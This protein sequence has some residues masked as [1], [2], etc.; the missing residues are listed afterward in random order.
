MKLEM[1][2]YFPDT[3][4][5]TQF[6]GAISRWVVL[7]NSQFDAW[8]FLSFL[9]ATS[10]GPQVAS[11]HIHPRAIRHYMSCWPRYCLLWVKKMN[12]KSDPCTPKNVKTGSLSRQCKIAVVNS[13]TVSHI[14]FKLGI[15]I[16]HPSDI[17]RHDLEV[18]R[19]KVKV[20]TSC[21]VSG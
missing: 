1:Y 20:T 6:Q 12:F 17:T 7:A 14:H 16:D 19:S 3:T 5:H 8:K 13:G 9:F 2:N 10:S 15:G 18:K 21:N 11:L 4:P